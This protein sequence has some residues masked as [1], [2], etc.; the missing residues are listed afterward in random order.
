MLA[1]PVEIRAAAN[2]SEIARDSYRVSLGDCH[3]WTRLDQG[4]TLTC[5]EEESE[6]RTFLSSSL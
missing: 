4:F 2:S 3:L 1:V 5:I 6:S